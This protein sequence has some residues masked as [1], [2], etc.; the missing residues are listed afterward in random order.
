MAIVTLMDQIIN[1]LEKGHFMVG[2]FLD[3]SKAFDTVNHS[4]LLAK[5]Y[6]YGI[7]GQA[8]KWI[9][10]YLTNIQQY[11]YL[12]GHCSNKLS[13]KCGVPLYPGAT[14]FSSLYK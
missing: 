8:N 6:K 5:L 7:R 4:I 14:T 9:E 11:C 10:N 1:A 2:I 3:F 12:N 13:I